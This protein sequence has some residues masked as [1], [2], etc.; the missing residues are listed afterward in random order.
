[1]NPTNIASQNTSASIGSHSHY[2]NGDILLKPA[3]S[4]V[5]SCGHEVICNKENI[6]PESIGMQ[7]SIL[8]KTSK[9]E[10]DAKPKISHL[11]K[12]SNR[13][14]HNTKA[15]AHALLALGIIG[16]A[17]AAAAAIPTGGISVMLGVVAFGFVNAGAIAMYGGS[18]YVIGN[19]N[20][21]VNN[22]EKSTDPEPANN[23]TKSNKSLKIPYFR[24][25]G[26]GKK[27]ERKK[28]E[29]P[30]NKCSGNAYVGKT[31]KNVNS[32]NNINSNNNIVNINNINDVTVFNN[33]Y[34][35]TNVT[36]NN[37]FKGDDISDISKYY[38]SQSTQSDNVNAEDQRNNNNLQELA[39]HFERIKQ[40]DEIPSKI[41][42]VIDAFGMA[43]DSSQL[44]CERVDLGDGAH[45][46]VYGFGDNAETVTPGLESGAAVSAKDGT[47]VNNSELLRS[48]SAPL[49]MTSIPS[50]VEADDGSA[51]EMRAKPFLSAL[52]S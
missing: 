27:T 32:H 5:G 35:C 2:E 37:K 39:N 8:K 38:T 42:D 46:F 47:E 29:Q 49:R 13:V 51:V 30:E 28:T 9:N 3:S 45:A 4:V 18:A 25:T 34:L 48:T 41:L 21:F 23:D 20:N 12:T 15:R 50:A 19:H 24:N 31:P 10:S 16:G 22:K 6:I 7:E 43:C 33:I 26:E 14:E 1:M 17:V 40:Q 44:R 11:V 52:S 36:F